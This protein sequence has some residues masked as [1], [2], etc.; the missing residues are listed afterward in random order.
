[1]WAKSPPVKSRGSPTSLQR[2][3][4]APQHVAFTLAGTQTYGGLELG[5]GLGGP[6]EPGE[7]L[8]PDAR[9]QM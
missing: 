8:A 9:Q 5:A 2:V 6:A 7:Q 1:V 4:L 3:E